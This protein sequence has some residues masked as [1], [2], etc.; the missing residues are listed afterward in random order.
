VARVSSSRRCSPA[1]TGEEAM[2]R[3][4]ESKENLS[5]FHKPEGQSGEADRMATKMT[6]LLESTF[7]C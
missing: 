2:E 1:K 5:K 7:L 4:M 3:Q 6:S